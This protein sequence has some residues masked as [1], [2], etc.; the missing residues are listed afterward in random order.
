M[1]SAIYAAS[2]SLPALRVLKNSSEA[3]GVTVLVGGVVV[4]IGRAL[5]IPVPTSI[6]PDPL[7]IKAD[8]DCAATLTRWLLINQ[9]RDQSSKELGKRLGEWAALGAFQVDLLIRNIGAT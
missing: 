6:L 1:T 8:T 9:K 7:F 5:H 4:S 3:G 2:A